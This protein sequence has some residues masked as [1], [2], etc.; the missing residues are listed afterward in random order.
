[1]R[2]YV[3]NSDAERRE[4]LKA[5]LRQIDRQ[6]RF[7]EAQDWRQMERALRR[8]H[9]DLVVIDWQNGM[10][11]ADVRRLLQHHPTLRIAVLTDLS[12]P[13]HV[14]ALMD[15][16]VLGVVPRDT[17]PRVMLRA[18][19]IVVLGGHYVPA[20]AFTLVTP[21]LPAQQSAA[22]ARRDRA[23]GANGAG[24]AVGDAGT[25]RTVAHPA[26]RCK[27]AEPATVPAQVIQNPLQIPRHPLSKTRFAASL[28]PRQQ[29]IMRCV[30]M[31]STNKM[32]ARTLGI[33]EGTVKI[34]LGSIF[35]QLGAS[36]RAA[37]VAL[38]NG[39]LSEQLEVLRS[40]QLGSERPVLG[41]PGP[42]PLRRRA[43]V[44]FR[45]P[46]PSNDGAAP[47]PIAA[48]ATTPFGEMPTAESTEFTDDPI[49][50]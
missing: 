49:K 12:T 20:R 25:G 21:T 16:G 19:E 39:W 30:H 11:V 47:L 17:D 22:T 31:G 29:Q 48:E 46:L 50:P 9:P 44:R 34:H 4:G 13:A 7:S 33:S 45:Y 27:T 5:L 10:S 23:A 28:S 40:E 15:E 18:F 36:N 26:P 43:P 2:F 1:M 14:R 37:A 24:G 42:V 35:Q 32:I 8:H 6:T 41:Q 38:Y 3:L